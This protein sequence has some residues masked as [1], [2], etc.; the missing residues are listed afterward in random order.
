MTDNKRTQNI[1]LAWAKKTKLGFWSEDIGPAQFEAIQQIAIGGRLSI[2]SVQCKAKDGKEFE[3]FV[4]EYLTPETVTKL[5]AQSP[6]KPVQRE[7]T[8]SDDI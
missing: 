8:D 4:F 5:K 6:R 7:V 1:K 3:S 2:K